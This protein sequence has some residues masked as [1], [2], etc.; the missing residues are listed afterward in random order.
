MAGKGRDHSTDAGGDPDVLAAKRSLRE[1]AWTALQDSGAARF[2]GARNRIPNFVGAEAAAERLR[3]SRLWR[4]AA[5]MKANPDSP[6]LRC[7]SA[8]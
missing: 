5:T 7:V 8:R 3:D 6:Q 4:Q 2:P 1:E